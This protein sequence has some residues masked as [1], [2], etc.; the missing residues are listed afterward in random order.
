MEYRKD[1]D[2]QLLLTHEQDQLFDRT[3]STNLGNPIKY[4]ST[5]YNTCF[6]SQK[7]YKPNLGDFSK[8]TFSHKNTVYRSVFELIATIDLYH[9]LDASVTLTSDLYHCTHKKIQL[10]KQIGRHKT[11]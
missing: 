9:Y 2:C 7:L 3:H 6:V 4:I 11:I 1:F 8:T 5:G 10:K